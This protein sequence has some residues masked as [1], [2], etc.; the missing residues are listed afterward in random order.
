MWDPS[1][2]AVEIAENDELRSD[3]V[4][5]LVQ[6]QSFS[7]PTAVPAATIPKIIVQFWDAPT[8]PVDVRECLESWRR[9]EN[10]GFTRICFDRRNARNFISNTLSMRHVE[11]F[12]RCYHPAMQSDYFRLCYISSCG[13]CYIDADD[14]FNGTN[15]DHLFEDCRLKLQPL[16]YDCDTESMVEP[17]TFT[18]PRNHSGNWIY[19]FN[20]NPIIAPSSNP[21][22][23]YA[24][25]R[26]THLLTSDSVDSFPE[27]QSTTGPGNLTASLAAFMAT[28]PT[29]RNLFILSDWSIHARTVW[30]LSYRED[31]RNWRLSNCRPFPKELRAPVGS[32]SE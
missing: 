30:S 25:Q 8:I 29:S 22:I 24:L 10:M 23:E 32:Q 20:N 4:Q 15:F 7:Q 26:A 27:I 21:I 18:I 13:G 9:L 28:E 12:N 31:A 16:C 1:E 19:Y 2:D 11:A 14:A 17:A 3:F 5:R 6:D